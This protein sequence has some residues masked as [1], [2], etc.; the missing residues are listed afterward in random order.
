MVIFRILLFPQSRVYYEMKWK[1]MQAASSQLAAVFKEAAKLFLI[2]LPFRTANMHAVVSVSKIFHLGGYANNL[3]SEEVSNLRG[4]MNQIIAQW[5]N[6]QKH[7]YFHQHKNLGY[8]KCSACRST[9]PLNVSLHNKYF[10]V[11]YITHLANVL[12]LKIK[13]ILRDV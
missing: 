8:L 2:D 3:A 5:V 7:L 9:S 1:V 13:Y 11:K 10:Q 6:E 12:E 4:L